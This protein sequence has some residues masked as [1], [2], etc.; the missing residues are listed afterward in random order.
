MILQ[1][2]RRTDTNLT[3]SLVTAIQVRN[4]ASKV[5]LTCLDDPATR[6]M[7]ELVFTRCR[8]IRWSND[9]A[10]TSPDATEADVI[11]FCPGQAS[12]VEPAVL[13]TDLFE[14]SVLYDRLDVREAPEDLGQ[15]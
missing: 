5:T 1:A 14:L 13:T 15:E 12:Y 11:G 4:W 10:V 2:A 9:D 6:R 8:E 3:P 7:Y